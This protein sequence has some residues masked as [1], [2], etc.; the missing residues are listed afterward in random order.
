MGCYM[1][2]SSVCWPCPDKVS[3][4][5]HGGMLS[6]ARDCRLKAYAVS[7]SVIFCSAVVCLSEFVFIH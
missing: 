7:L 6:V 4:S 5:A 2:Y 1:L 3:V